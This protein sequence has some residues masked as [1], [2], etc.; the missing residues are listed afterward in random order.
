MAKD[1]LAV[2]SVNNN[3]KERERPEGG[4]RKGGSLPAAA[5]EGRRAKPRKLILNI[6][7]INTCAIIYMYSL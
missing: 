4:G 5:G 7:Y 2:N 1:G 3:Y 6:F